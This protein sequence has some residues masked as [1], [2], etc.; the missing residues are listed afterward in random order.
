MN[1]FECFVC[2]DPQEAKTCDRCRSRI[3]GALLQLPDQYVYLCA[4]RQ[5]EQGGNNGGRSA[6]R[7]HAPLPGRDDVLNLLG[8]ASRQGVMNEDQGGPTPFLEV[9]WSWTQAVTEELR[10][11]PVRKHV[12]AM[13]TRL[14]AHLP[15]ICNQPWVGDF[16]E[17]IRE[18]LRVVQGVTRTKPR[19]V[20]LPGVTCPSCGGLTLIREDHSGWEA[21][22]GLCPAVKLDQRDYEALVREQSKALEDAKT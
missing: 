16:E 3:R 9:L 21:E 8:P 2:G 13:T 4:S 20:P 7:L 12:T 18:L 17:E 1:L 10:L 22:C 11:T 6:T 15:W 5:R 14:T 19:R